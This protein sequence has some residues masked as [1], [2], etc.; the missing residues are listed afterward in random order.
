MPVVAA[1]L[2]EAI[3]IT[4]TQVGGAN[5]IVSA[6]Q[7]AFTAWNDLATGWPASFNRLN[8]NDRT[9][10]NWFV[11]SRIVETRTPAGGLG[12]FA[13]A[14]ERQDVVDIVCRV[15]WA[16]VGARSD[17]RITIAQRDAVLAAWNASWGAAV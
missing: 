4:N 2:E 12:A 7:V 6:L 10:R 1:T 5:T 15:C 13:G 8:T 9:I 11:Q 16:A 17:G 14:Q 3:G